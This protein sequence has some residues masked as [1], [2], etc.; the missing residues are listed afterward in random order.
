MANRYFNQ[1]RFALEAYPTDIF[2]QVTFAGSGTPTLSAANSKGVVSVTRNN[3]GLYTF[4]FGTTS[5][6]LDV[7][8][9]LL[10]VSC[11][12]DQTA[13]SNAPDAPIVYVASNSV[14]TAG[15]CSVQLG[16]LNGSLSATDPESSA[17]G[18]ITFVMK[19][20]TTP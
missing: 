20:S 11:V 8:G 17:I 14:A 13:V 6:S 19:N 3:T 10:G 18:L 9:R 15:T 2:A 16:F 7:Y 5:S 1:F 4:V 12:F